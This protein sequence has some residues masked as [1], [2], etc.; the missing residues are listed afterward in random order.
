VVPEWLSI[1]VDLAVREW[2]PY[3]GA[4]V[5]YWHALG[6]VGTGEYAA[7]LAPALV[8]HGA[9]L[10][11][12]DGPGHGESPSLPRDRYGL[13]ATVDLAVA[14]LNALGLR[15]VVF[16]GHS[17][18]GAVGAH[19]AAAHPERVAGLVLLDAGYD[20]AP[21]PDVPYEDRLAQARAAHA[22]WRWPNWQAFDAAAADGLQR[23]S[24]E[25]TAVFRAGVMEG[26]G[27]LV[28]RVDPEARASIQDAL[29]N[30]SI[31]ATW[32]ALAS[33]PVLLLVATEP[34]ELEA[35]RRA[36]V[37]RF[38][39]AVPNAEVRRIE[40]AGH[41]LLADAGPEVGEIIAATLDRWTSSSSN[42]P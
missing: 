11:A 7:E 15:R 39:A 12:P 29:S 16:V 9:R 1:V 3:D 34:R 28:A 36:A 26:D 17:W 13:G 4:P 20:D 37:E 25:L 19:L 14:L 32:P 6:P 27:G 41:D 18:G 2:G 30:D 31:A 23:T 22:D 38:R 5:L 21:G 24:P 40:G 33:L 42:A 10:L 35:G 8:G